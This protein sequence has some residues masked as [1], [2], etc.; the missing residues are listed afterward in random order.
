MISCTKDFEIAI[1]DLSLVGFWKFDEVAGNSRADSTANGNTITNIPILGDFLST[2]G[3]ISNALSLDIDVFLN[4]PAFTSSL[5][6]V[7]NNQSVTIAGWFR[8][9]NAG[10]FINNS[11]KYRFSVGGGLW[12]MGV[13]AV[14]NDEFQGYLRN[15]LGV[16]TD[17]SSGVIVSSNVYYF[18][19]IQFDYDA[20]TIG[21][22]V[23][24]SAMATLAFAGTTTAQPSCGFSARNQANS[25]SYNYDEFG[26]WFRKLTPTEITYLYNGGTGRTYPD[27]PSA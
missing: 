2:A 19:V 9:T 14:N 13:I 24:D 27:V 4:G 20:R 3:K 10:P 26:I 23:N 15:D 12:D 8:E 6:P 18:I 7:W 22:S 21:I 17:V 25:G 1:T 16:E 11:T 5:T